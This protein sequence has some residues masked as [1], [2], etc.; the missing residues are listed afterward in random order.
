MTQHKSSGTLAERP[1]EILL[2]ESAKLVL[3]AMQQHSVPATIAPHDWVSL[4]VMLDKAVTATDEGR[5][6][7]TQS[8]VAPATPG[9]NKGYPSGTSEAK[10]TLFETELTAL[11]NRLSM[12]N[13]SN[14]P[15]FIIAK[16]LT[17]QLKAFDDAIC[18]RHQWG[19]R[20]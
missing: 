13:G 9:E 20:S 10:Y 17:E 11:L 1:P 15:D 16:M 4:R 6:S 18:S 8:T 3:A 12:E 14:T 5:A 19:V 7:S 2:L